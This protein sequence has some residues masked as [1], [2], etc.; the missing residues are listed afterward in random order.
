MSEYEIAS[1][2][3][4]EAAAASEVDSLEGNQDGSWSVEDAERAFFERLETEAAPSDSAEDRRPGGRIGQRFTYRPSQLRWREVWMSLAAVAILALTLAV[5][6]YRSGIK[7][8]TDIARI[9]NE[10]HKVSNP[11]LEEQAKDAGRER[12]ELLANVKKQDRTIADLRKQLSDQEKIVSRLRAAERPGGSANSSQPTNLA[13]KLADTPRDGQLAAA[14]AK[15]LDLQKA[16]DD[17]T[18][19]R[20]SVSSRA[21]TLEAKVGELTQLLR[22]RTREVD[23]KQEEVAKLEELLEYDRDVRELMASR[24]LYMV[25]VHDVSK[26]GTAK[27]YGRVLYAKGKRLIFYAFDLDV[28]PGLQNARS[29]QAWGRRGPDKLQ[30]RSLGLFYEDNVSKKRWV[31][32][33][34]DPKNLE[35]IDAVFVTVEPN[36]GSQHRSDKQLLF[37]YLG[38]SPNHP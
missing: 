1:H 26:S 27:T 5:T 17:L 19:Q 8:G 11:S 34:N 4:A 7:R 12:A 36:G 15:L 9:T 6:A 35:D 23:Q 14:Q 38:V 25:D 24:D 30:A 32:K 29:F 31:L 10:P 20:D 21:A 16:I 13:P 33:A 2:Q 28:Q 37:A 3:M 18:N 22:D